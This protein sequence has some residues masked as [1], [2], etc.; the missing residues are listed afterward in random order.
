MS[1]LRWFHPLAPDLSDL[2]GS[3]PTCPI[4]VPRLARASILRSARVKP[5][6]RSD[7]HPPFGRCQ[8]R[9]N[10][11]ISGQFWVARAAGR[12]APARARARTWARALILRTARG[13]C[14]KGGWGLGHLGDTPSAERRMLAESDH[15]TCPICRH[16]AGF[17]GWARKGDK[18]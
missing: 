15:P 17:S 9:I 3:T 12:G 2:S 14:P 4:S 5:P 10:P 1:D 6:F 16:K 18:G 13:V 8:S 11:D 7:L